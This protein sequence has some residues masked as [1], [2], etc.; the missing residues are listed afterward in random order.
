[1]QSDTVFRERI[2]PVAET[3][4]ETPPIPQEDGVSSADKSVR[5]IS[6]SETASGE[7]ILELF[8]LK[9]THNEM[10]TKIQFNS[11]SKYVREELKERG[12]EDNKENWQAILSE[13]EGEIGTVRLETSERMK[14]I[15]EFLMV[16]KKYKDIKEKME[17]YKAS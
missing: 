7:Y 14:K 9:Q 3:T 16:K 10:P 17:S 1:M 2:E 15:Y 13:I 11:L 6:E 8:D 12:W 4:V 5:P